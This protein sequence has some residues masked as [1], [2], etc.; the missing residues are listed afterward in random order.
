MRLS[1]TL[2]AGVI[3]FIPAAAS[4]QWAPGAELVGQAVTV[5]T[6][7]V[8]NTVHFDPN[9]AARIVAPDGTSIPASWTQ[10]PNGLC[11]NAAGAQECWSYAAPLQAGQAVAMTSSC[12]SASTWNAAATNAPPPQPQQPSAEGE[13]G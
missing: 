2:V 1:L 5:E 8:V 11:L 10:G 12:G 7:G 4:A 3:G 6:N 9:G 13:R